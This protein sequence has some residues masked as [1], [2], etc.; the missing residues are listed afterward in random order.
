MKISKNK[1]HHE[2]VYDLSSPTIPHFQLSLKNSQSINHFKKKCQKVRRFFC[3]Q[4]YGPDAKDPEQMCLIIKFV[5]HRD[6]NIT[7]VY[8]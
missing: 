4:L 1:T 6:Q 8:C 2:K 5:E 3:P 7:S